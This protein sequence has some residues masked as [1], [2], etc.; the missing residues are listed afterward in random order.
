MRPWLW[1]APF[2]VFWLGGC[3]DL[4]KCGI[5]TTW[6]PCAGETAEVGALGDPPQIKSFT[7]PTCAYVDAPVLSG[8]L[9]VFDNQGDQQ[10][11]HVTTY[12]GGARLDEADTVLDAAHF[13]DKM[14]W[15]G[16]ISLT[17]AGSSP[18]SFDI[19]IKVDDFNGGQSAPVCNT[20][21]LVQ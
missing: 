12:Q 14:T 2:V 7:M 4:N 15:T 3:V 19:R 5:A 17:V 16:P 18:A 9:T 21:S 20:V 6:K 13:T 8:M 1:L 10:V 11:A